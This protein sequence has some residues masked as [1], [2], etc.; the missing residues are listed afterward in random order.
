MHQ[1]Y[2]IIFMGM[3]GAGKGTQV[4][5]LSDYLTRNGEP[6]FT[7]ETG[8]GFRKLMEEDNYT[9]RLVKDGMEKGT[10]QPIFLSVWLWSRAFVHDF[11]G[12]EDVLIDGFPRSLFEAQVLHTAM[13]F[14]QRLP[15]TVLFL[16]ISDEEARRRLKERAR[17]DDT[18][19]AINARLSWYRDQVTPILDWYDSRDE[20]H[21]IRINGEQ[22]IEDVHADV[23]EAI[24]QERAG[25]HN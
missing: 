7:F 14:Y 22:S 2:T 17:F 3:Q 16:D 6:I 18:D 13:E 5:L 8:N 9:A 21:Y 20:Y 23:I 10:L 15:A 1:P 4:Q 11:K 19:E 24:N 12:E 25:H